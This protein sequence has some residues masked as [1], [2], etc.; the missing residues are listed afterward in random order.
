[1][2]YKVFLSYH[3][4]LTVEVEADN[5][6]K[7][8]EAAR[9]DVG[10]MSDTEF[11]NNIGLME[12]DHDVEVVRPDPFEGWKKPR[13]TAEDVL[14]GAHYDEVPYLKDIND[15]MEL[16]SGEGY[17]AYLKNTILTRSGKKITVKASVRVQGD[18]RVRFK[19]QWYRSASSMPKELIE[20]YH[21]GSDPAMLDPDYYVDNNNWFEEFVR[22]TDEDGTVICDVSIVIDGVAGMKDGLADSLVEVLND[23][24]ECL[25]MLFKEDD[26][27]RWN[28]PDESLDDQ[29]N[30]DELLEYRQRTF[31]I[32][33][34]GDD[35][36]NI[37]DIYSEA[38]VP[39]SEL[40][41][42]EA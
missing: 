39:Y 21:D 40:L 9:A 2:K 24:E 41:L 6:Q 8:L 42:E 26:Q 27:V 32:F 4:S 13:F 1:M 11:N 12:D 25:G 29:L 33:C 19:G 14:K 22:V 20:C 3:G 35:F 28:D 15:S 16:D 7:A 36:A 17:L 37:S 5:E 18:V 38:Q 23:D 31:R 10:A 34:K 30:P